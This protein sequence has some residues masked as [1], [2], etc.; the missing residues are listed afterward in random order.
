MTLE[1]LI[2]EWDLE[3]GGEV[4][5]RCTFAWE[6]GG[7]YVSQRSEVF[8]EGPP[9][10]LS[11]IQPTEDGH[12]QHY[13]D[14]RGVTRLYHGRFDGDV[15]I[16]ER[17]KPDFSELSFTQRWVGELRGDVIAGRWETGHG[18]GWKLDFELDY[19]RR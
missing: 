3:V 19:R 13:F 1:D 17:T 18:H 8:Q 10:A 7:A 4:G 9:D 16:L 12:L 5:G 14:S 2:G 11:I 6:L 15:W